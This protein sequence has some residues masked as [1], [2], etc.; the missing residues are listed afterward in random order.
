MTCSYA[1]MRSKEGAVMNHDDIQRYCL[2]KPGAFLD[3]PFC[4]KTAVVKVK[5]GRGAARIFAQLFTLNGQLKA[6]FNCDRLTGEFYRSA[7]P[8]A[9]GRGYHCPPVQQPFFNTVSLDGT[10]PDGDIICM[11]DHACQTA[12]SRMPGYA[13]RELREKAHEA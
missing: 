9:V 4:P 12:V 8:G 7:Y 10:V 3:Y 1:I 11:I 5:A 2:S 13:R 6:T